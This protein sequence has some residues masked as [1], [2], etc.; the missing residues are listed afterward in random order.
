M[1]RLP[2]NPQERVEALK[3]RHRKTYDNVM[4]T[5]KILDWDD[6]E[7]LLVALGCVRAEGSGSR[8]K[9][10]HPNTPHVL[11]LHAPHGGRKTIII[12][13]IQQTRDYLIMA[14]FLPR[15]GK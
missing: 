13:A 3:K 4:N 8:V 9:F 1:K 12:W 6:V 15:N 5:A 11:Q 7:A 2:L 10:S 14:G